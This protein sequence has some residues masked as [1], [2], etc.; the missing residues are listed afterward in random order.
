MCFLKKFV[1][2]AFPP[3]KEINKTNRL[4]WGIICIIL[5]FVFFLY[6]SEGIMNLHYGAICMIIILL[7]DAIF[8]NE[9]YLKK[10]D[11][12]RIRVIMSILTILLYV[13]IFSIINI[14]ICVLINNN[15]AL[16]ELTHNYIVVAEICVLLLP[17][18]HIK[19]IDIW[20][21]WSAIAILIL[22][23]QI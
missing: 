8:N 6:D 18:I 20:W 21:I 4:R 22:M 5:I 12:Y 7:Q 17:L 10:I 15:I 2:T 23:L 1:K 11:T 3:Y 14:L 19:R 13:A 9:L 16:I